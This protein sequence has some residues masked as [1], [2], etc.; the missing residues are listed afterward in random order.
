MFVIVGLIISFKGMVSDAVTMKTLEH[1]AMVKL[2]WRNG[3]WLWKRVNRTIGTVWHSL[4]HAVMVKAR[5]ITW[6]R[7]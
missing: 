7:N 6:C 2:R 5:T 1:K 3:S 4:H